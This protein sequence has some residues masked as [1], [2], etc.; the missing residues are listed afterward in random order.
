MAND[1]MK[2]VQELLEM[3]G[4]DKDVIKSVTE[5][6]DEDQVPVD[7]GTQ[8]DAET[9]TQDEESEDDG[10]NS[11]KADGD[12]EGCENG[13]CG[14]KKKS[15]NAIKESAVSTARIKFQKEDG[16]HQ[17]KASVDSP[18]AK[19]IPVHEDE[20]IT[21]AL[22]VLRDAIAEARD[23]YITMEN[24]LAI[25]KE[26]YA[27]L[28][29]DKMITESYI[30]QVLTE[31]DESE[32]QFMTPEQKKKKEEEEA[33]A[34]QD[35][36]EAEEDKKKKDAAEASG[37]STEAEEDQTEEDQEEAE[38]DEEKGDAEE[39]SGNSSKAKKDDKHADYKLE[40]TDK[41]EEVMNDNNSYN[42][43][44]ARILQDIANICEAE[45]AEEK[46]HS[47]SNVYSAFSNLNEA[48]EVKETKQNPRKAFT[49][50]PNLR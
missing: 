38:E 22:Y 25:L 41:K 27:K 48:L 11:E 47:K 2:K 29:A 18:L 17:T 24:D 42:D 36:Q 45:E 43:T 31:A 13:E 3:A 32:V 10:N 21:E 7:A 26:E 40:Q 44:A 30:N 19:G 23:Q 14:K 34:Q 8:D 5:K 15:Q 12:N 33:G 9:G 28:V 39:T 37:N 35:Q 49:L 1:T 16:E 6:L 50:F 4:L 46:I 20:E